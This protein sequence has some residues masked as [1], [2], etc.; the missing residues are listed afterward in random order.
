MS[1]SLIP[2]G[3][4]DT[5]TV[6]TAIPDPVSTQSSDFS[7]YGEDGLRPEIANL[8][9]DDNKAAKS[10]FDKYQTAED[11]NKEIV[12]GIAHMQ[13]MMGQKAITRP[14]ENAPDHVK[15]AF[16]NHL[17]SIMQ[18]PEKPEGYGWERPEAIPEENWDQESMDKFA[19][20]LHKGN[21]S[22]E[23]ANELF[24]AYNSQLMA[25]P[26]AIEAQQAQALQV[27]RDKLNAEFGMEADKM[28]ERATQAANL[29][30]IPQEEIE[31]I[32]Q[33]AEGIKM[34]AKLNNV[35]TSDVTSNTQ[36]SNGLTQN[37]A[38]N[39]EEAA[40]DAGMK[41]VEAYNRGDMAS[42]KKF[43]DQQSHYNS[44]HL[45]ASK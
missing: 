37:R 7:F 38:S 18:T 43:S 1:D 4:G 6:D 33:T 13:Y 25:A 9:S 17:R 11:P 16:A 15:E 24:E 30:G 23:T 29:F 12:N 36:S 8:I 42:Y 2:E 39:Y 44:L 32:G 10:F 31:R 5:Q 27:E 35:V 40:L 41:A 3:G 26:E 22:P 45:N 14:D 21:V 28:I 34:L 19:E 20:I